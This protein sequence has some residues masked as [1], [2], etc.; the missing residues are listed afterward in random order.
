MKK[1]DENINKIITEIKTLDSKEKWKLLTYNI[2][3][4]NDT[5]RVSELKHVYFFFFLFVTI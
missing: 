2:L 3:L 1:D 4:N 5:Y